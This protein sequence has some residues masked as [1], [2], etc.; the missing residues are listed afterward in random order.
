MWGCP[1]VTRMFQL[2]F[3]VSGISRKPGISGDKIE[4][5][6]FLSMSVMLDHDAVDG[7]EAAR[8]LR[9]L[10]ELCSKAYGLESL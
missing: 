3:G 10:G 2:L 9:W 1:I 5:R 8:F 6:D 4:P 7:A